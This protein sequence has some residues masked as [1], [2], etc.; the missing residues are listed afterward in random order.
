MFVGVGCV[1]W[2][3]VV[4]GVWCGICGGVCV[5]EWLVGVFV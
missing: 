1:V 5:L 4:V 2:C 3:Y